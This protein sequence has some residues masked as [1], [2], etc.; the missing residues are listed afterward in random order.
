M[1]QFKDENEA[2]YFISK[3]SD[4]SAPTIILDAWW[5][6]RDRSPFLTKPEH[7]KML[8]LWSFI[9]KLQERAWVLLKYKTRYFQNSIP[10]DRLVFLC[11]NHWKFWKFSI[12]KTKTLSIKL[13]YRLLVESSK[14]NPFS[15]NIP[16]LYPLKTSENQRFSEVFRGYRSGTFVENG[17]KTHYLHTKLLCQKPLLR[18]I[19]WGVQS[20]P[21]IKN[22]VFYLKNF[23]FLVSFKFSKNF[24]FFF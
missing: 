3:V 17:L 24:N 10:F 4:N 7:W 8:C 5:G 20:G 15:S 16:L 21:T 11:D 22:G 18:Q 14:I 9:L 13:E 6:A 12:L 1:L 2:S 19:E 23:Y